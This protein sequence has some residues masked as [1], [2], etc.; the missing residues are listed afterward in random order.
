[1]QSLTRNGAQVGTTI[2]TGVVLYICNA[3]ATAPFISSV[4]YVAST[5]TYTAFVQTSAVCQ[6]AL[7]FNTVGLPFQ[8]NVCGG[9]VYD[10]TALDSTDIFFNVTIGPVGLYWY[11]PCSAVN[12]STCTGTTLPTSYCQ[13]GGYSLGYGGTPGST[14]YTV[15]TTGLL[16]QQ[17]DGTVCNGYF[18]RE[19]NV[20]LVCNASATTPLFG[21][22][23]EAPQGTANLGSN[24]YNYCHYTSIIQTAAVCTQN[25]AAVIAA[26][27]IGTVVYFSIQSNPSVYPQVCITGSFQCITVPGTSGYQCSNIISGT[28]NYYPSATGY[29]YSIGLATGIPTSC[30]GYNTT[31]TLL[32]LLV[33]STSSTAAPAAA[34]TRPVASTTSALMSSPAL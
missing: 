17:Q 14:T 31:N 29:T 28:H 34:C 19:S 26:T 16:I 20:Y 1:M 11:R 27:P 7:P 21:G 4:S 5:Y 22:F 8:S 9:G 23:S 6:T 2:Y 10:L 25:P 33:A 18:P 15:T 13:Y 3:T 12:T 32:P 24:G 30:A